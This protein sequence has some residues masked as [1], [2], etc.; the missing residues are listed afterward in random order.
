LQH[1]GPVPVLAML[2]AA[3]QVGQGVE[4]AGLEPWQHAAVEL[5]RRGDAETTIAVK[6]R[7]IAAVPLQTFLMDQEH[8]DSGAVL[9]WILDLL[10]LDGCG[11]ERHLRPPPDLSRTGREIDPVERRRLVEAGEEQERLGP[12]RGGD[13][14]RGAEA[15]QREL[16][17][18]LAVQA[19]TL[20]A[21]AGVLQVFRHQQIAR[22]GKPL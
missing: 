4:A 11:I 19:E 18:R 17:L 15:R 20:D 14:V 12:L 10:D 3:A 21:A 16:A 13:E 1:A 22:Q 9:R 2:A 6:K 7:G 8:A 5:R